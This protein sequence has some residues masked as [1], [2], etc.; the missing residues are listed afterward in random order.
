MARA[1]QSKEQTVADIGE[2]GLLRSLYRKLGQS[3]QPGVLAGVGDDAA[4]LEQVGPAAVVSTDTLIERVDFD[5]A[6]A[7]W[8]DVGHKAAAVNLSDLAA[9]GASPRGLLLSLSV[10]GH[11]R[12]AEVMSLVDALQRLGVRHGAPLVGGDISAT[13]GP[14]VVTVTAIGQVTQRRV[15]RRWRGR[16]GDVILVTGTLGAAAAG[17]AALQAGESAP[18]GVIKRQLRPEPRV[19]MGLALGNSGKVRAAADISDGLAIDAQH[20]AGEHCTVRLDVRALPLASGVRRLAN[21]LGYSPWQW[22]LSGGEDFELVLAVA[23]KH[24]DA[25]QDVGR[26][27]GVKLSRVG[28]VVHG[29]APQL[30]DA[31]AGVVPSGYEHFGVTAAPRQ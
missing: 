30:V 2:R 17:L 11:D 25:L 13:D 21:Q 24:V 26:Q 19:Q 29:R 20:L 18:S 3:Q 1:S 10:R 27:W 12:Y 8:R 31:P 14:L 15:L 7:R 22:G 6:W 4:L 16:P 23:P 28:Q 5:F 9:M